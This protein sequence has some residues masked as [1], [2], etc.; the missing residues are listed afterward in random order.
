MAHLWLRQQDCKTNDNP[1]LLASQIIRLVGL[2]NLSL[3]EIQLQRWTAGKQH[4]TVAVHC[5]SWPFAAEGGPYAEADK[6]GFANQHTPANAAE[7]R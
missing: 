5:A 6:L 1:G 2:L 7:G 3:A 4:K